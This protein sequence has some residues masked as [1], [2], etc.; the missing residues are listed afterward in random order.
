MKFAHLLSAIA[1]GRNDP[2]TLGDLAS[3]ALA[4]GEEQLAIPVVAEQ[5]SRA[6]SARLW[7]WLGLLHRAVDEHGEAL[8][9]FDRA[10]ALA[11]N[12]A[13]IAHG[14]ARVALE[15]GRPAV[16]LFEEALRLA[17]SDSAV[18]LGLA[19]AKFAVGEG[20]DAEALLDR[21]LA[22]EPMWLQGHLQLAQL[23][24]MLGKADQSQASV[25]RAI[26][27][28]PQAVQLWL[29]LFDIMIRS[30]HFEA[31]DEAVARARGAGIGD[32]TLAFE[33][34]AAAETADTRRA[35][36]L[37]DQLSPAVRE[38][39]AVWEIRH[40][41]RS[42]RAERTLPLVERGL[43]SAAAATFWPYA[44]IAW[45]IAGDPRWEWLEGDERLVSVT[46]LCAELPPIDQLASVLRTR[47]QGMGE[48]LDQSVRGGS[49]T[50]G[51]IFSRMEPEIRTLRSA[52]VGAVEKHI[53]RLPPPD[54]THPTLAPRRDREPRFAGS[55]SVRLRGGG[56]HTSH[57]HPQGW[58]SSAFYVALPDEVAQRQDGSGWLTLG[59]APE[60]LGLDLSPIR[61]VEPREGQLVLFPSWMWHGTNPFE[62]GERM[63][64]AFDVRV[65]N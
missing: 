9:S 51:A 46:D 23:R 64:V 31:L 3:A 57:V 4:E 16:D 11:P 12:D 15:G 25:E 19:A 10:A 30:R 33:A 7:Q 22:Q 1:A 45:R 61:Q 40:L 27:Q 26:S 18:L 48:F 53:A 20:A 63:T 35:D 60:D 49:Q 55:W 6:G 2:D 13:G 24:S 56:R 44:S 43:R 41:L 39:I 5:A 32:P 34:V 58:I 42:G 29:T 28:G 8:A 17:P 37:F 47:H 21:R 59:G 54:R 62:V 36:R 65:P 14:R 38:S 52:I 50:D